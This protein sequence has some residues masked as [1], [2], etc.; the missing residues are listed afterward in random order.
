M[1]RMLERLRD[2]LRSAAIG[3]ALTRAVRAY[4]DGDLSRARAAVDEVVTATQSRGSPSQETHRRSMRL[5]A[6]ALRA[7]VAAKQGD[8]AVARACIEEGFGLWAGLREH[9]TAM[10]PRSVESFESWERWARDWL[11]RSRAGAP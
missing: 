9:P 11:E 4:R 2:M 3:R 8:D 7:E 10:G 1:R 6:V 5:M